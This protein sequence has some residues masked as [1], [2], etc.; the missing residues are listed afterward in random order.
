M[1]HL[2]IVND[3]VNVI[4]GRVRYV[5]PAQP[6]DP[7]RQIAPRKS[8]IELGIQRVV[9]FDS[10]QA[11]TKSLIRGQLGRFDRGQQSIPE[12]IEG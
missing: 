3:L 10:R 6:F 2:R 12:F 5:V 1:L 7:V 4:D 11:Q 9:I 8:L